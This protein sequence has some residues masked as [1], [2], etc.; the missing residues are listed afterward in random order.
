LEKRLL[1]VSKNKFMR[2]LYETVAISVSKKITAVAVIAS[3]VYEHHTDRKW[4]RGSSL[5]KR[6]E[7]VRLKRTNTSENDEKVR[8]W[9]NS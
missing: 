4:M 6:N 1:I 2:P 8:V 9:V 7:L 5:R 3:M